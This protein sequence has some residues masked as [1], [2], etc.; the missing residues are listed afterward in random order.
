MP[1]RITDELPELQLIDSKTIGERIAEVRKEKGLTQEELSEKIG[2]KRTTIADYES[3]RSRI[4]GETITRIALALDV[5]TDRLLGLE[6]KVN[7]RINFKFS[8]LIV[9]L[10]KLPEHKKNALMRTIEDFIKANKE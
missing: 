6:G 5:T 8:K 1:K 7:K 10:E 9:E 2:I 3:N 4:F